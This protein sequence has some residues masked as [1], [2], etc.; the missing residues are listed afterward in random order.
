[1]EENKEPTVLKTESG[2]EYVLTTVKDVSKLPKDAEITQEDYMGL[3]DI[4]IRVFRSTRTDRLKEEDETYQEYELRRAINKKAEK[5]KRG[6]RI[7]W[8][9]GMWGTR[10]QEKQEKMEKLIKEMKDGKENG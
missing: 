9:S 8:N 10:S 2:I 7:V 5:R 3:D 6:G 4:E 1:M